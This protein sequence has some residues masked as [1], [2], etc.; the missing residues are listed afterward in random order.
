MPGGRAR[1]S[2]KI[3]R[4][5]R[6]VYVQVKAHGGIQKKRLEC[7]LYVC[8]SYV[9]GCLFFYPP[10]HTFFGSSRHVTHLAYTWTCVC[11]EPEIK[12]RQHSREDIK[13]I[14]DRDA[15]TKIY[16]LFFFYFLFSKN[17]RLCTLDPRHVT[18]DPRLSTLDPRPSTKTQTR[19]RLIQVSIN[20]VIW[21]LGFGRGSRVE[22]TKSRV[23]GNMSR[24]EG[25]KSRV[26]RK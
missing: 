15:I 17:P 4:R 9:C 14:Y 18:L 23:E 22:G 26:L 7:L 25:A 1:T 13:V 5:P 8:C 16:L 3:I 12:V 20:N 6:S 24:V 21:S 19:G 2:N 10:T 11:N